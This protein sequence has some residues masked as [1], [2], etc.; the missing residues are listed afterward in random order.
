MELTVVMA[1]IGILTT[2]GICTIAPRY[3]ARARTHQCRSH[4]IGLQRAL[5]MYSDD[6]GGYLVPWAV[7]THSVK[8]PTIKHRMIQP[9]IIPW[10]D[11]LADY[12]YGK[13]IFRCLVVHERGMSPTD[14]GMNI[15]LSPQNETHGSDKKIHESEVMSPS[16]TLVFGDADRVTNKSQAWA[17]LSSDP[18]E[19]KADPSHRGGSLTMNPYLFSQSPNRLINRHQGKANVVFLDGHAETLPASELGFQYPEKHQLAR[20]DFL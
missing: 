19:W 2:I 13:G 3:K 7:Q 15:A 9:R 4:A 5:K 18:D 20:W 10:S 16:S 14:F 12:V 1:I 11:L 8:H 6:N 17:M